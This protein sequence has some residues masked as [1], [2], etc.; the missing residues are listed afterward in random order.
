MLNAS[1]KKLF[2]NHSPLSTLLGIA[3]LLAACIILV[4]QDAVYQASREDAAPQYL[5][6]QTCQPCHAE[7]YRSYREVA[8]GRSF[9]RPSAGNVIEDYTADNHLFHAPSNRHYRMVQRNGKF[10]QRRYQLNA[11]GRETNV[12]ELEV[13]HIMG[14][15]NHARTYLNLDG[16]GVL[17][18]LP[19]S[20]YSQGKGWGMSPGYDH[21][22]HDDFRR[23]VGHSCMF[24]H[25]GYPRLPEPSDR[26]GHQNRFP[27]GPAL[28]HRLPA[29]PRSG[30]QAR[31]SSLE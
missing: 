6:P 2:T 25:N 21:A 11:Q 14:S 30:F 9:Y 13:T 7:I 31:G 1:I 10:Y 20:W 15:G 23:R 8:M 3:V 28:G 12:F 19:V 4:G 22:R 18:Q 17:R 26:Y 5:D 16:N 27:P 29:L 24:C